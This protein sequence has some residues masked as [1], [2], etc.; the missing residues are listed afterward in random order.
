MNTE[1]KI[2]ENIDWLIVK[3]S[4]PQ[5]YFLENHIIC[6]FEHED[7]NIRGKRIIYTK[8]K[9]FDLD[10][11]R[12]NNTIYSTFEECLLLIALGLRNENVDICE[13][14]LKR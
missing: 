6:K 1:Q 14:L 11:V 13:L 7:T 8:Y 9:I 10:G 5:F 3:G 2:I 4:K 12:I